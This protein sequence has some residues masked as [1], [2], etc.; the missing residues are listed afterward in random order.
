MTTSVIEIS[1][2]AIF[3]N[4]NNDGMRNN[5]WLVLLYPKIIF[6]KKITSLLFRFFK[7]VSLNHLTSFKLIT[8][9]LLAN[10]NVSCVFKQHFSLGFIGADK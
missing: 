8:F 10:V 1:K 9:S 2:A 3:G 6:F 4:R 7:Y 5:L